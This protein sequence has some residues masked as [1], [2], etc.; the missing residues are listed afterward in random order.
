MSNEF[1]A[2][3]RSIVLFRLAGSLPKAHWLGGAGVIAAI[4]ATVS[5]DIHY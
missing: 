2:S 5:K 3:F 1:T 4:V